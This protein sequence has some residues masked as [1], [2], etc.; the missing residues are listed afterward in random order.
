MSCSAVEA[1]DRAG[2]ALAAV[3]APAVGL[4]AAARGAIKGFRIL[5]DFCLMQAELTLVAT[6]FEQVDAR[7]AAEQLLSCQ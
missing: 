2:F 6:D 7:Q 3:Q 5:S 4:P 1:S